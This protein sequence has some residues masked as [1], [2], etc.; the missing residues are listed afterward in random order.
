[1][2][3]V[4]IG[5]VAAGMSA[6][7]RARTCDRSLEI[8]VLE[9]GDS[10]SW[11]ACGLPYYIEGQVASLGELVRHTPDYFRTERSIEVRTGAEVTAIAHSR[12]Q[13]ELAGGER[14]RYDRL[15]IATGAEPK[16]SGVAGAGQPHV[17]T[18]ATQADA[19]RLKTFLAERRP[20]RAAIAGAGY[21][22]L[23]MAE[24]FRAHGCAVTVY[25]AAG[26]VLGR[27]DPGLTDLLRCHLERFSIEL[28]TG[29]RVSDVSA[30]GAGPNA[31][32]LVFLATGFRPNVELAREAGVQLGPTG[33]IRVSD[34]METSLGGVYAAGDCAETTHLVSGKPFYLPLGTTANKMGRVAGANAAGRRARFPGV[35]GTLIVRVCGLGVAVTGLSELQAR[36]DG[37]DAVSARIQA[38]NKARY[39]FGT[40]CSAELVAERRTGR[41]LGGSI[42]AQEDA[43][44]RIGIIAAAVTGRMRLEDF[45]Y[46]D[47]PYAPPYAQVQDPLL[48]AAR[49]LSKLI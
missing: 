47:L 31:P 15:V 43:A 45:E 40:P 42:V 41:I 25:E 39:F 3:L 1:M 7:S 32:D 27:N 30:L 23:G 37:F 9:R 8:T 20:R 17:F 24:V 2:H 26:E 5:G 29:E 34:R 28:R 44:G 11:G 21:L 48:I 49:Q 12:R 33:A 4:V 19:R 16:V 6:A 46:L 13:V 35:A 36:R 14:I 38:E 18:L 22:G 10:V